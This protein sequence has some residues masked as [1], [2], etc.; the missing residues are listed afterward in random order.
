MTGERC[1]VLQIRKPGPVFYDAGHLCA[2]SGFCMRAHRRQHWHQRPLSVFSIWSELDFGV[3][4][5]IRGRHK[6]L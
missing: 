3:G 5:F 6:K 1:H 2:G 4:T